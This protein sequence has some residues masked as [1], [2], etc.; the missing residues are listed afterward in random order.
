M[1]L[2]DTSVWIDHFRHGKSSLAERLSEGVVLI[3]PVA[4]SL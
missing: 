3:H 2:A 4:K 1:V